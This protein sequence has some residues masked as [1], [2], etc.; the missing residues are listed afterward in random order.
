MNPMRV[1]R[2]RD[3]ANPDFFQDRNEIRVEAFIFTLR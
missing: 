1:Y 3:P 2:N